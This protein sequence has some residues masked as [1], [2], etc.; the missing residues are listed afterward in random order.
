MFHQ[1]TAAGMREN[2]EFIM[3]SGVITAIIPINFYSSAHN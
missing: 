1:A 3:K 2:L